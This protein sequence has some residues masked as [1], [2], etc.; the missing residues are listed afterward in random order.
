MIN[1]SRQI[2]TLLFQLSS[3]LVFF[4]TSI[5]AG[6]NQVKR[7]NDYY[8]VYKIDDLNTPYTRIYLDEMPKLLHV[9]YAN[10]INDGAFEELETYP[11]H[12]EK[13]RKNK[14]VPG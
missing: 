2:D 8:Q 7:L 11:S 5:Q 9:V 6:W 14:N 13:V 10:L 12:H 1:T 4:D 3:D